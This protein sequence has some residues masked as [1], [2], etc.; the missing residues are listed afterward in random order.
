MRTSHSGRWPARSAW[1]IDAAV[2]IVAAILLLPATVDTLRSSD[3]STFWS[4]SVWVAVAALHT[5]V[6]LVRAFPRAA[7]VAA[8][9]AMLI[10]AFAPRLIYDGLQVPAAVLPSSLLFLYALY[11]FAQRCNSR[12]ALAG[13]ALALT[14]GIGIS[15]HLAVADDWASDFGTGVPA[16]LILA[17]IALGGPIGAWALG[18]LR[19]TRS[20]YLDELEQRARRTEEDRARQLADAA[21]AERARI[22]AEMHDVV[23]HSLAVIVSQAEGGRM[24][25]TDERSS[26]VLR[27]IS[28][29]GRTALNEMRTM[30]GVLSS[31]DDIR[32]DP[33][34]PGVDDL[35]RL[36]R[37]AGATYAQTGSRRPVPASVG[38]AIYRIAQESLT[39]ALKHGGGGANLELAYANPITLTI[40]N[41]LG[42][43]ITDMGGNG[44][45]IAGMRQRAEAV[46]GTLNAGATGDSWRVI[47]HLPKETT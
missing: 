8:G 33:P 44:L 20:A 12:T 1:A 13:L 37:E 24:I 43:E 45:G 17:A 27:T 23:S 29:T 21:A 30:L 25:A 2:C 40:T 15:A 19:A 6:V 26:E 28:D 3:L 10:L 32:R 16:V 31:T 36:A 38:L 9:V 47:A 41:P 4:A 22:A 34:Q 14:G 42:D 11:V 39:N 18:R 5:L 7:Y 46:G 35:E